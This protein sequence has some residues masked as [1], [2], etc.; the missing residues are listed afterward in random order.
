M[1]NH[2]QCPFDPNSFTIYQ[3]VGTSSVTGSEELYLSVQF[4]IKANSGVRTD[5]VWLDKHHCE[6]LIEEIADLMKLD[7]MK[8]DLMRPGPLEE[9]KVRKLEA[10][11][12]ELEAQLPIP[13]TVVLK[14]IGDVW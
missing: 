4:S 8:L 7:L 1:S 14:S 9:S 10:R 5:S 13:E 11:I 6:L 12:M 2:Y 3:T